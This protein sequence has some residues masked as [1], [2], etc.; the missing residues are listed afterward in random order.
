MTAS[1]LPNIKIEKTENIPVYKGIL[2]Q[3]NFKPL[4]FLYK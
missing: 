3:L 1:K 2:N 4:D